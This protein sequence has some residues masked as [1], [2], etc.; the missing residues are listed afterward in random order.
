VTKLNTEEAIAFTWPTVRGGSSP[1]AKLLA[2]ID[3]LR[4]IEQRAREVAEAHTAS[5]MKCIDAGRYILGE[6]P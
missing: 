6:T 1:V 3:R 4:A 2:E 5:P